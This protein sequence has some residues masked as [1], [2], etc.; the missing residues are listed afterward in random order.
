MAPKGAAE[1][2][3][4]LAVADG[5]GRGHAGAEA[6]PGVGPASGVD[7]PRDTRISP[8]SGGATNA[9]GAAGSS[10][11]GTTSSRG[12]RATGASRG[13]TIGRRAAGGGG[14]NA[15]PPNSDS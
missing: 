7:A 13:G 9:S 2:G 10:R 6:L 5:A 15:S 1:H 11:G 8:A 14:R 4:D 3:L 12:A